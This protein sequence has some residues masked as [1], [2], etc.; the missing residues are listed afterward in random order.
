MNNLIK[1]RVAKI[2]TYVIKNELTKKYEK[3]NKIVKHYIRHNLKKTSKVIL[4][5]F[6]AS[7]F[8]ISIDVFFKSEFIPHHFTNLRL[9][10]SQEFSSFIHQKQSVIWNRIPRLQASLSQSLQ[11]SNVPSSL[12]LPSLAKIKKNTRSWLTIY[13]P[14]YVST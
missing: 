12:Q 5:F 2:Q 8:A 14:S 6:Q 10:N 3:W 9:T 1:V 4:I 13:Q 11:I 7:F